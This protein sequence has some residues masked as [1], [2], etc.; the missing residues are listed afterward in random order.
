MATLEFVLK[1]MCVLP[2]IRITVRE[3]AGRGH[4]ILGSGLYDKIIK[5]YGDR[6]VVS[7]SVAGD[8]LFIDVSPTTQSCDSFSCQYEAVCIMQDCL[9]DKCPL[10][11]GMGLCKVCFFRRACKK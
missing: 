4:D 8:V 11:N 7:S 1:S 3:T 6:Q 10:C 2:Y 5:K 9:G